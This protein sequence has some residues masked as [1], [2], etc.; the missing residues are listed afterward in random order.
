MIAIVRYVLLCI[1]HGA[2]V[3]CCSFA[4]WLNQILPLQPQELAALFSE[5][6]MLEQIDERVLLYYSAYTEGSLDSIL[7]LLIHHHVSLRLV[8]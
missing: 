7:A 8:R 6:Q 2:F 3:R 4:R 1:I 5:K